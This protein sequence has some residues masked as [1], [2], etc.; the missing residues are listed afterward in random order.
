MFQIRAEQRDGYSGG[1]IRFS[2]DGVHETW[3]GTG[4]VFGTLEDAERWARTVASKM[5][6]LEK[7]G[8]KALR[9][10]II[11]LTVLGP[12]GDMGGYIIGSH[13]DSLH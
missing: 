2:V 8:K 12:L 3:D 1:I 6:Y 5:E 7:S 11:S 13:L 10:S 4:T 9:R